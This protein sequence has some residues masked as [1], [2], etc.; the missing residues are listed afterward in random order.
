MGVRSTQIFNNAYFERNYIIIGSDFLSAVVDAIGY[1]VSSQIPTTAP[2]L[3][4]QLK[5]CE[6]CW[7]QSGVPVGLLQVLRFPLPIPTPPTATYSLIILDTENVVKQT[8][9][10]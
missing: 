4:S 3:R 5:S 2:R 8:L 10:N 1:A 7:G 9:Q 6:I